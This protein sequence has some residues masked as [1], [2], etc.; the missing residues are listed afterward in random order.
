MPLFRYRYLGYLGAEYLGI[1]F[2]LEILYKYF[3]LLF[4]SIIKCDIIH[5]FVL[6]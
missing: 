6:K 2:M 4:L 5:I 3:F 1:E